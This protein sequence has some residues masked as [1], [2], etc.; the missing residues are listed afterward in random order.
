MV[1]LGLAGVV[2][3]VAAYTGRLLASGLIHAAT[4]L[5]A[6]AREAHAGFEPAHRAPAPALRVVRTQAAPVLA[7]QWRSQEV[8]S[9]A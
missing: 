5:V 4:L 3:V 8:R 7:Q 1:A 9:A 6:S 2:I